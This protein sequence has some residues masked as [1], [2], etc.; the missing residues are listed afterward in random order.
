MKRRLLRALPVAVGAIAAWAAM[1]L[2]AVSA[3]PLD[4][5]LAPATPVTKIYSDTFTPL[6]GAPD[7]QGIQ[8]HRYMA[9]PVAAPNYFMPAGGYG[10]VVLVNSPDLSIGAVPMSAVSAEVC[11]ELE[12]NSTVRNEWARLYFGVQDKDQN[13]VHWTDPKTD[14]PFLIL[15]TEDSQQCHTLAFPRPVKLVNHPHLVVAV[16]L[17][18]DSGSGAVLDGVTYTLQPTLGGDLTPCGWRNDLS[19]NDTTCCRGALLH[20]HL[21]GRLS[22]LYRISPPARDNLCGRWFPVAELDP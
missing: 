21:F 1:T 6:T 17:M 12:L 19:G 10:H 7:G 14:E 22:G 3:G 20:P 2:S 15:A 16:E 18:L 5:P 8:N 4:W 9:N 13:V 11:V